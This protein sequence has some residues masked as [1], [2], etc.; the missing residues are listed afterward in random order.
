MK[1]KKLS[2]TKAKKESTKE[3]DLLG[4]VV[5]EPVE[6]LVETVTRGGAGG[7]HV[8][9]AGADVVDQRTPACK[10]FDVSSYGYSLWTVY[11]SL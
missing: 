2:T 9:L 1:T 4:E 8:P 6:T 10:T 3:R 11:E 5:C 7:L